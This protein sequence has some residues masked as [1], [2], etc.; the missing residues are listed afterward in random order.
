MASQEYWAN[1]CAEL[2]KH[3]E[4][5]RFVANLRKHSSLEWI[6]VLQDSKDKAQQD[7]SSAVAYVEQDTLGDVESELIA[8]DSAERMGDFKCRS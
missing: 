1:R 2:E 7:K 4:R 5:N 8:A 6:M 3:M